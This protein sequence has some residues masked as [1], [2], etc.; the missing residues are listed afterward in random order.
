MTGTQTPL[1]ITLQ[2]QGISASLRTQPHALMTPGPG[3]SNP[4]FSL[5]IQAVPS[6][7]AWYL[8]LAIE[9]KHERVFANGCGDHPYWYRRNIYRERPEPFTDL[10]MAKRAAEEELSKRL[11]RPV[12]IC[13]QV[14]LYCPCD[15]PV[16]DYLK[17]DVEF[18]R[19]RY[20]AQ[21][22]SIRSVSDDGCLVSWPKN[23]V[24][25]P[26]FCAL[27]EGAHIP[28][29]CGWPTICTKAHE[30]FL[31]SHNQRPGLEKAKRWLAWLISEY[32]KYGIDS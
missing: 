24:L 13:P 25:Q 12:S 11:N 27:K 5:V 15:A 17:S 14:E 3:N 30:E 7:T 16:Y 26:R 10:G 28:A 18:A 8:D 6:G 9:G 21:T 29:D 22:D 32:R 4:G 1:A 31:K 2:R 19:A 23:N 20:D